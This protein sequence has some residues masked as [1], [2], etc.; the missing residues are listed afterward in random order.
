MQQRFTT[1]CFLILL[2]H[3]LCIAQ[4]DDLT[5]KNYQFLAEDSIMLF[6]ND[7]YYFTER[8]CFKNVR[9]VRLNSAGQFEGYFEDISL[10]DRL[11]GKGHYKSGLK[12]GSFEIYHVNGQLHIKGYYDHDEPS[13]VWE[14]FYEDGRKERTIKFTPSEILLIQYIDPSGNILVSDGQ[15]KFQGPVNPLGGKS[16]A[17]VLAEGA[18]IDGRPHGKWTSNY[19]GGT[20]CEEEFD[21]GKFLGGSSPTSNLPYKKHPQHLNKFRLKDYFENLDNFFT[22]D[23]KDSVKW[24]RHNTAQ[25]STAINPVPQATAAFN[26]TI[27]ESALKKGIGRVLEN[28]IRTENTH[29]YTIGD[30]VLTVKIVVDAEGKP[31]DVSFFAGWGNQFV[32]EIRSA[33]RSYVTFPK[34]VDHSYLHLKFSISGGTFVNYSYIFSPNS[35]NRF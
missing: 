13:G 2:T 22:E 10:K 16:E 15:G 20:F 23:C 4:A 12:D 21:H 8:E 3:R 25:K 9:I 26:P 32:S 27:F 1:I 34:G 5:P 30:H 24:V 17:Y 35:S 14:Y 31:K 6:F 28:D 18:V 11:L 29:D 19:M 33:I 7:R